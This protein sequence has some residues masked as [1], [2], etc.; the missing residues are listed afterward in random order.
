MKLGCNT[1]LFNQLDLYGALQ[2]LSWAGY[3]GAELA[4]LGR[5]AQHVELKT[6]QA[7]ID[8]VRSI[9]E[10]HELE[11]F[12][13]EAA[14]GA[15][16]GVPAPLEEDKIRVMTK[17]FEVANKLGIPVVAI[18]SG[19]K[20]GDEE[21]TDQVFRF[22]QKLGESAE[23]WG[24]TLAVKPHVGASV[25]NVETALQLMDKVDSPAVGINFD[26]SHLYRAGDDPAEAALKMTN[27]IVHSHFR[28]CPHRKPHPGLPE[29]QI[30]GRGEINIAATLRALRDAGYDKVLDLEVI[31][32]FTYPLSRQMGIAAEARGYLN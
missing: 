25:Y 32:A 10:K 27:N 13:I 4:F 18:G 2:H 30:P 19:G 7:Y 23:S 11:L 15:G 9:A 16:I 3:D 12:A 31:G 22:I 24:I 20:S 17:V 14:V 21:K 6:D 8:S 29:Q 26:P 5:M 1:V 28:D